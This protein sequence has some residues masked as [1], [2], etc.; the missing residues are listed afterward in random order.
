P[1]QYLGQKITAKYIQPQKLHFQTRIATLNDLQK[2]LGDL[3]W[4]RPLV[5]ITNEELLPFT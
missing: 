3:Q 2:L 5:G 4:L 1:W